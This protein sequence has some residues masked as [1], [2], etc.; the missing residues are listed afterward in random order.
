MMLLLFL[1]NHCLALFLS[2][3]FMPQTCTR[4]SLFSIQID[5][6]FSQAILSANISSPAF[7]SISDRS[8][9]ASTSA[10]LRYPFP[11][12]LT[13]QSVFNTKLVLLDSYSLFLYDITFS[14]VPKL[15]QHYRNPAF[16][17][18][19]YVKF[20]EIAVIYNANSFAVINFQQEVYPILVAEKN[21]NE[22][23]Q[24]LEIIDRK[25]VV[26]SASGVKVYWVSDQ[27]L[28]IM[29]VVEGLGGGEFKKNN[30][31]FTGAYLDK[32]L[33]VL[34]KSLGLVQVE[35]FPLRIGNTYPYYGNSLVGYLSSLVV[36]GKT[37]VNLK[38][39]AVKHYNLTRTCKYLGMDAEFVYCVDADSVTVNFISRQIDLISKLVYPEIQGISE[40][41]KYVLVT[42]KDSVIIQDVRLGPLFITGTVPDQVAEYVVEFAVR[43]ETTT[44]PAKF[45]LSV[46]YSLTNVV[47]FI[48]LSFIGVFVAVFGSTMIFRYCGKSSTDQ[49][50]IIDTNR[51][52]VENAGGTGEN[53]RE[54]DITPPVS[55]DRNIF[56]DRSL[57]PER[58]RRAV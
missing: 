5:N 1:F 58:R 6:H 10:T 43:D 44:V 56:S 16:S 17:A 27:E 14:F 40:C 7:L 11:V 48:L 19:T 39:L 25:V 35:Y 36:D 20:R 9:S 22:K 3:P 12:S 46:Q 55:T 8:V 33:W 15:L 29:E 37:E 52:L 26:G 30:L 49:I 50:P 13:S 45:L 2:D 23:I 34:E 32:S 54:S 28:G 42:L 51:E 24:F 4:G 47:I 21:T 57:I 41:N 31:E 38:N 53:R 18:Y